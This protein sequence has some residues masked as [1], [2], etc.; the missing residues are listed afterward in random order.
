MRFAGCLVFLL[1]LAAAASA[2]A[3][4]IARDAGPIPIADAPA[5][6]PRP[7][8]ATTYEVPPAPAPPR[9]LRRAALAV[10]RVM[11][12]AVLA[13]VRL[14]L[15]SE[16][17]YQVSTRVKDLFWNDA[18]TIGLYPVATWEGGGSAKAGAALVAD[19]LWGAALRGRAT[20][21]LVDRADLAA[22]VEVAT[23]TAEVRY[24]DQGSVSF[25]GIGEEST[26]EPLH[27][28]QVERS[29]RAGAR[30]RIGDGVSLGLGGSR[31]Q[32]DVDDLGA[33]VDAVRGE[34]SL[35][36]DRRRARLPYQSRAVPA[37]GWGAQLYAGWQQGLGDDDARFAYG[38]VDVIKAFDFL[39]GD[40][41]VS[42][43][44]TVDAIGAEAD[45]VAFVDLPAL[46]GSELLRGFPAGR[47]RDRWAAVASAEYLYPVTEGLAGFAFVDAGRV[48]GEA[49]DLG[50]A[51]RLGGGLGVQL[52]GRGAMRAR[53]WVAVTDDGGVAFNV[54]L[55]PIFGVRGR[56]VVR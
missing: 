10:P 32:I 21:G 52:H 34:V 47:F 1:L 36:V 55:E 6:P 11:T 8:A 44:A 3:D 53:G 49:R 29:A 50:V 56:E 18:R 27:Y 14:A 54:R 31:R 33:E 19:E 37:A 23:L 28:R 20:T 15:W 35:H 13:P 17:R 5:P 12:A 2:R 42:L 22:S 40:R 51:P 26:D 38:G 41:V 48:A 43:R 46:G 45:Q 30:W 7:E 24:R 9:R 4:V 39:G 16:D 25:Y